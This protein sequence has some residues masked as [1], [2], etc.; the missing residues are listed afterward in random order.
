MGRALASEAMASPRPVSSLTGASERLSKLLALS[1]TALIAFQNGLLAQ[2]FGIDISQGTGDITLDD[3][4]CWVEGEGVKHVIVKAPIHEEASGFNRERSR[5]QLETLWRAKY[6][7]GLDFTVDLYVYLHWPN[8]P[9]L[10]PPITTPVPQQVRE[11]IDILEELEIGFPPLPIGRL[12][13]DV[14]ER[15]QWCPSIFD[16]D[17]AKTVALLNEALNECGPFPCGIY[18]SKDIWEDYTG[19]TT[20]F[21]TYPLWY[22]RYVNSCPLNPTFSD[23]EPFG[24][25]TAPVGKQY[26]DD[27]PGHCSGDLCSK[28]VDYNTMFLGDLA[29]LPTVT[30]LQPESETTIPIVPGEDFRQVTLSWDGV[31]GDANHGPVRYQI[32]VN[33]GDTNLEYRDI[34]TNSKT[35]NLVADD[36]GEG[37]HYRWRV[38]AYNHYGASDWPAERLWCPS[39]PF[40]TGNSTVTYGVPPD[41]EVSDIEFSESQLFEGLRVTATAALANVGDSHAGTFNVKWFTR[42]LT[43]PS[44]EV[45]YGGHVSL[46]PGETSIDNIRFDWTLPADCQ[47]LKFT[48]DPIVD[49]YVSELDENNN[50]NEVLVC[51]VSL[52]QVDPQAPDLKV[53]TIKFSSLPAAGVPTTAEAE[54]VNAGVLESGPFQ[55]KWLLDG[56][57]IDDQSHPSLSPGET[58]MSD[59]ARFDWTPIAGVHTLRFVADVSDDVL[60]GDETNNAFDLTVEVPEPPVPPDL[61]VHTIG[62][63]ST[64]V[65]GEP[66]TSVAEV[67]NLGGEASGWVKMKW[68]LDGV[69]VGSG[70]LSSLSSGPLS[71]GNFWTL[72]W[73]PTPGE[74]TLRFSADVDNTVEESDETNN[75]FEVTVDVSAPPLADA[76]PDQTVECGGETGTKIALDGSN[77]SDPDSDSLS[78]EWRDADGNVIGTTAIV[79]ISLPL[80]VHEFTLTV[81]DAEGGTDTDGVVITIQDT[82][83]PR[84]N[85]LIASP[86]I[87][88]PPNH[89]MVP[90]AI[91]VHV[92]DA[93]DAVP[94]C[95]ITSVRSSESPDGSGDGNTTPDWRILGDLRLELRAERSGKSSGR[96][97]TI[98]ITCEDGSGNASS[99]NVTVK[100]P[101]RA[102]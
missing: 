87:L 38:R 39:P 42:G 37:R 91:S 34:S 33:Y 89:A 13:I 95:R 49:R 78:F 77:S 27:K 45:G 50:S 3:V 57:E 44:T 30:G 73:T 90:V 70:R 84:I 19:N 75:S 56:I 65:A 10:N 85:G 79:H 71:T 1:F 86:N 60:E 15:P 67:V 101:H 52:D 2:E 18:T 16:C 88:W 58:S 26:A 47:Y 14:E 24:G 46:A 59:P 99:K 53:R 62:F 12:W 100:V 6:E 32:L 22:A 76:G 66:T 92:L 81:E 97:Y 68:F 35:I 83:P 82:R 93:C 9:I 29:G 102:R 96:I 51:P 20:A 28:S 8:N 74:H 98:E 4:S 11:A 64:P 63:T 55:V 61:T 94:R 21:S 80:G 7:Q 72:D 41:L 36:Q 54:L 40:C 23:F 5:Q 31:T 69:E 17:A 48:A 43:G 25:W